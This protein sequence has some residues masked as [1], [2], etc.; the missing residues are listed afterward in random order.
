MLLKN[1]KKPLKKE[2]KK[3][4]KKLFK[5]LKRLDLVFDLFLLVKEILINDLFDII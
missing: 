5:I 2:L 1:M 4:L 3:D